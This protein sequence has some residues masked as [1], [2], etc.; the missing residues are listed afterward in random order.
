MTD[1]S[2]LVFDSSIRSN[3]YPPD[4]VDERVDRSSLDR[5][6]DE[7]VKSFAIDREA[8]RRKSDTAIPR[9][10]EITIGDTEMRRD[11]GR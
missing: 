5:L 11:L 7:R 1:G 10:C 6:A 4:F 3:E 2:N 8:N 9:T